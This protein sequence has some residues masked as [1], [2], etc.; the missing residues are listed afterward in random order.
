MD[1]KNAGARTSGWLLYNGAILV[2]V[3]IIMT[4][5][6]VAALV[7]G[8]L[9]GKPPTS[10]HD[11]NLPIYKS[12]SVTVETQPNG[13]A[14]SV[15]DT[16][17]VT[18]NPE[19][20]TLIDKSIL[21]GVYNKKQKANTPKRTEDG[22]L[23]WK[24]EGNDVSYAG[25][26]K[27][28]DL[29]ITMTISYY[30]NGEP[31][32][33]EDTIGKSGT[34]RIDVEYHNNIKTT[35][36]DGQEIV[37]PYIAATSVINGQDY[38]NIVVS[39]GRSIAISGRGFSVGVNLPGFKDLSG[40]SLFGVAG[41]KVSFSGKAKNF[42]GAKIYSMITSELIGKLD[43]QMLAKYDIDDKIVM[44]NGK[45][46]TTMAMVNKYMPYLS[47]ADKYVPKIMKY[48]DKARKISNTIADKLTK[49]IKS[50]KKK[51]LVLNGVYETNRGILDI[52]VK[53]LTGDDETENK[54]V[55]GT[56]EEV[57]DYLSGDEAVPDDKGLVGELGETVKTLRTEK[58][59]A[60]KAK[61]ATSDETE[62][63]EYQER[64]D[65]LDG[66][67]NALLDEIKELDPDS[68]YLPEDSRD[69][70]ADGVIDKQEQAKEQI[71]DLKNIY[72]DS[73]YVEE[74][75][76]VRQE[77]LENKINSE[78]TSEEDR[79][80]A[81]T[82]LE[83]LKAFKKIC[84]GK[85]G[86][87]MNLKELDKKGINASNIIGF[88]LNKVLDEN[89]KSSLISKIKTVD[90]KVTQIDSLVQKYGKKVPSYIKKIKA[91]KKKADNYYAK[92][93]KYLKK[94]NE[95]LK[96]TIPALQKTVEAYQKVQ[97]F[98]GLS[99]GWKGETTYIFKSSTTG[100]SYVVK[101]I[102]EGGK[103]YTENLKE[104]ITGEETTAEGTEE[105]TVEEST[106][107][108]TTEEE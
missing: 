7:G 73:K 62:K 49:Y 27:T 90:D 53:K 12:E 81:K 24:A 72:T 10:E 17:Y 5:V 28:E 83:Q 55:A 44:A 34:L 46:N 69:T 82:D 84:T 100:S 32:D 16:V 13:E 29:P 60:E 85:D 42:Q 96:G 20:E 39:T 86:K 33:A 38:S 106:A 70:T 41:N 50:L 35:L 98:S 91:L 26:A 1:K 80:K 4:A 31:I 92:Y 87:L 99:D 97:N 67:I 19:D 77:E 36:D 25:R 2:I 45:I 104:E 3:A 102:E 23:K 52:L 48:S 76:T 56:L 58:E 66:R 51:H 8:F 9:A 88:I 30:L 75:F 40:S 101:E 14:K 63:Q 47:Y 11:A 64:I 71:E 78:S 95:E 59:E 22:E 57:E 18:N 103:K 94:Y 68:E 79:E 105:G 6:A 21:K 89:T 37:V 108:E 43:P 65:D 61:D 15:K 54:G 74:Y 93:K 107:E